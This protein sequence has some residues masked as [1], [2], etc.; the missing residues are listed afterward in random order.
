MKRLLISL[1]ILSTLFL[2][3]CGIDDEDVLK[4]FPYEH[5]GL[6]WSERS[7]EQCRLKLSEINC[8]KLGGRLPTISELRMTINNCPK[9][10]PGGTCRVT[11]NCLSL[12]CKNHDC[13]GCAEDKDYSGMY[14]VFGDK[15]PLWSSSKISEE[16]AFIVYFNKAYVTYGNGTYWYRCVLGEP[17]KPVEN[18]NLFPIE[19]GGLKWSIPTN[20]DQ[21]WYD[22]KTYCEKLG[23]RLPTI[24]ELRM[25][26]QNCPATETGGSCNVTDRCLSRECYSDECE[27]CIYDDED[28]DYCV[29]DYHPKLWSSSTHSDHDDRAWTISCTFGEIRNTSK[30]SFATSVTCV[31]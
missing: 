14:S 12:D 6:L 17:I 19:H 9:I 22:S 18:T 10:E 16:S 27:E 4:N 26:I 1:M 28:H 2:S 8:A 30:N 11:D 15:S 21:T 23:G 7:E 20:F 29:L 24:S 5:G 31:K 25:L 3:S 13:F